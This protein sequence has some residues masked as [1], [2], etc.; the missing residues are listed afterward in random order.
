[1]TGQLV[2]FTATV[3]ASPGPATGNIIFS[4]VGANGQVATCDGGDTQP[5][6]TTG[7]VTTAT[8]AFANGLKARP[9]YYTVSAT[10]SDPN[11][12]A[13]VAS[14]VQ[15]V[16]SSQTNTTISGVPGSLIAG[17]PFSFTAT[18]QDVTPGAGSPHG[19]ME[20]GICDRV[21]SFCG[22]GVYS[23]PAPTQMDEAR[24]ENQI[25]L[26]VPGGV[27]M[28]GTYDVFAGYVGNPNY[29]PSQSADSRLHVNPVPT[30]L[31][32]K[33][34]NNPTYS[35]GSEVLTAVINADSHS[36]ANL[37]APTGTVT[38]TITGASGDTL[39]CEETGT[40]VV[41][42]VGLSDSPDQGTAQCTISGAVVS[43]DSPYTITAQ[44][45]GDAVYDGSTSGTKSI[46]VIN[47]P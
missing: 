36:N 45:S 6:S 43:A 34:N 37:P 30:T 24:N 16:N 39:V 38:F 44:Y 14:L 19:Q 17:Q 15:S 33:A 42:V 21:G 29:L 27:L 1:M 28:P 47:E 7:G 2:A 20:V 32:V 22:G 31:R 9:L 25:T 13:A 26:T 4:V 46:T 23:L 8:C 5:L 41:V 12:T 11:Y 3:T 40:D 35:Q 18:V 10:L